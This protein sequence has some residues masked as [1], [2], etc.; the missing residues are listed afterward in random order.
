MACI[1][2]S[3]PPDRDAFSSWGCIMLRGHRRSPLDLYALRHGIDTLAS[4]LRHS[5]D[6][7]CAKSQRVS[8]LLGDAHDVLDEVRRT[9][10]LLADDPRVVFGT[11]T[12]HDD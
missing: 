12:D 5:L 8:A 4:D 6:R 9:L 3:F 2:P 11:S 7:S 1:L 10:S